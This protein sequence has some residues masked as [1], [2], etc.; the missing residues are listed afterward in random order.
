MGGSR[1]A[2]L[3]LFA[4]AFPRVER[5]QAFVAGKQ[6]ADVRRAFH[7]RGAAVS[8]EFEVSPDL[9][10]HLRVGFLSPGAVYR[11]FGRFSRSQSFHGRD[12]ELDQR[13][14]AFRLETQERPQ[15]FLFSNTPTSFAPDPVMF[16]RVATIFTEHSRPMVPLKLF[17]EIG[18]GEGLR[19]LR[20]LLQAPDRKV[21][22]T[23]QRYWSRTPFEIGPAAARFMVRPTSEARRVQPAEDPD[24]LTLDLQQDLRQRA[25]SFELCAQLFVDEQQT[26]IEDSSH[27]WLESVAPPVVLGRV[28]LPQQ[29]LDRPEARELANR[30][31]SSEAF[32]PWNTPCLHPLGRTNRARREAYNRSA[33]NRGA[34]VHRSDVP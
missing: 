24:F 8:V 15:D 20:N 25:R 9:P 7:N 1:E 17:S 30:I 23:S 6:H 34:P 2:E 21:A 13:G 27:E 32:N 18:I 33:A 29:D 11:G 14:F 16:L 4:D 26:P 3:A 10:E 19:V 28:V 31:E 22:F 12:G 5:I